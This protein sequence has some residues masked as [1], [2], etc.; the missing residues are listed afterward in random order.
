V[1]REIK[2]KN[3]QNKQTFFYLATTS[4]HVEKLT[5]RLW[6]CRLASNNS[7]LH[8]MKQLA[9]M[10]KNWKKYICVFCLSKSS[11]FF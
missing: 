4:Y 9:Q 5:E 3:N 1:I 11:S 6:N 7:T 10:K 8:L 2:I